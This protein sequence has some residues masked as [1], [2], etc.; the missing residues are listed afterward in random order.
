MFHWC[1]VDDV[2]VDALARAE[3]DVSGDD[4]ESMWVGCIPYLLFG[5]DFTWREGEFDG[6]GKGQGVTVFN[7][8][9]HSGSG[10]SEFL[11]P[12]EL[13]TVGSTLTV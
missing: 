7:R 4:D 9:P 3:T 2:N 1:G 13:G 10:G 11:C 8:E 5:R 12:S 6:G